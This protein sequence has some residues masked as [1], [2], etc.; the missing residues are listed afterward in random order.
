MSDVYYTPEDFGLTLF[1]QVDLS[2][3]CYSF[4]LVAVWRDAA[5]AWFYATDA[6]CSCPSPFEDYRSVESL[7]R[8]ESAQAVADA[9]HAEETD[10]S[11][12]AIAGLIER[13]MTARMT[14][15]LAGA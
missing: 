3:P 13:I 14:D 6:G 11:K 15:T 8:A 9:L 7:T 4:D 10:Y 1:G 5:G 2:E 12:A